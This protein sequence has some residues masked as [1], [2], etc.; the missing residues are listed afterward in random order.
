[1]VSLTF[2]TR[3]QTMTEVG[4]RVGLTQTG[5][6]DAVLSLGTTSAGVS[7]NLKVGS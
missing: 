2:R 6:K 1:L 7:L 3:S 5:S 4:P